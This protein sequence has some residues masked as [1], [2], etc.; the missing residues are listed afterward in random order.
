MNVSER[1]NKHNRYA[2]IRC[3]KTEC[4]SYHLPKLTINWTGFST[5]IEQL[6]VYV[7]SMRTVYTNVALC[8]GKFVFV[9]QFSQ[10]SMREVLIYC[11][12]L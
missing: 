1:S 4:S 5:G 10:S 9:A 11:I 8:S 6:V 7:L 3:H 12:S 2:R